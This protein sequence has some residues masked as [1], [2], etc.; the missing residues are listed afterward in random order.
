MPAE[1]PGAEDLMPRGVFVK[2]GV[3]FLSSLTLDWVVPFSWLVCHESGLVK[4]F[5][6][7]VCIAALY[8]C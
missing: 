6:G 5:Q 8:G 2:D 1:G 7:G 3:K 4:T